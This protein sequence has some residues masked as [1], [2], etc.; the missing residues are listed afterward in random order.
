[1]KHI[2]IFFISL[3]VSSY[4]LSA[5]NDTLTIIPTKDKYGL[6]LGVDL[7]TPVTSMFNSNYSGFEV[8]A[9]YRI[10]KK[11]YLAAELGYAEKTTIDDNITSAAKGG[12]LKIG[13]DYNAHNNW[14]GLNNMI[15]G[16]LRYAFASFS[17]EL[18]SYNIASVPPVFGSD[19][20]TEPVLFEDLNAHWGVVVFGVKTEVLNNVYL[21]LNLQL[22]YRFA[23]KSPDNFENLYIPGFGRTYE[24][25][26]FGAGINYGLSYLIPF[27]KK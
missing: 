24:N 16:G 27:R 5:Q 22:N 23:D 14:A 19:S 8:V 12:Y 21:Y 6:R 17:Q 7:L 1:M 4:G 2:Y 11:H 13:F 9:D 15:Y 3:V 25:S 18:I 20:R 26:N 10:S